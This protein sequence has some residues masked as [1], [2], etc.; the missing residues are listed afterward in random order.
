MCLTPLPCTAHALRYSRF[1]LP[2]GVNKVEYKRDEKIPDAGS[3]QIMNEDHT[4]GNLV[5]MQ[6]H[7]DRT[8]VFAGYRIPHPL[9]SKMVVMIQTNG[10]K[11][12]TQAMDHAL[13]DLR[14]EFGS[15]LAMF[16]DEARRN[17]GVGGPEYMTY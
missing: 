6:L 15:I 17:G 10:Q 3:F 13:D 7:E 11:T 2:E 1:I 12:P 4:I 8:V 5:R 9:E 16:D 14:S